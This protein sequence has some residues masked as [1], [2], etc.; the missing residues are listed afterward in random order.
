MADVMVTSNDNYLVDVDND[1]SSTSNYFGVTHNNGTE[2]L[3]V[4]ENG[5]VGIGTA[6]P[7]VKLHIIGGSQFMFNNGNNCTLEMGDDNNNCFDLQYNSANNYGLVQSYASNSP[8]VFAINPSGGNVG[9]G[10]TSPGAL[11]HIEKS[12]ADTEV[13]I[14]SANHEANLILDGYNAGAPAIIIKNSGADKF[15]IRYAADNGLN[16]DQYYYID[17]QS[18]V[19]HTRLWIDVPTGSV[20]GKIHASTGDF[21]VDA[22][23]LGLVLTSPNGEITRRVRLDNNGELKW[24]AQ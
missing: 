1:S 17:E 7:A 20:P 19:W 4:Q 10:T 18:P 15:R 12:G 16:I 14:K 2:L 5:N 13:L 24:T 11:L 8:G 22:A 6:S 21:V 9:I 3:R 23:G